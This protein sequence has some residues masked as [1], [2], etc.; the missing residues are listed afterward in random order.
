MT[1]WH[2]TLQKRFPSL[3]QFQQ[4]IM[5]ANELNRAQNTI[6]SPKEYRNALERA[7]ELLD[8]I[9]ADP[10]W[11]NKLYELRRAREVLAGYYIQKS[12]TD[13]QILQHCLLQLDSTAWKMLN[14]PA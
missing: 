14:C 7:L 5:V 11:K 4:L 1:I 2:P 9:A 12:L 10:R 13:T 3:P 8:F 6:H